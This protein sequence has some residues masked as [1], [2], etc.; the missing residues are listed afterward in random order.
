MATQDHSGYAQSIVATR[1]GLGLLMVTSNLKLLHMN[2]KAWTLSRQLMNGQ[3][4]QADGKT[5]PKI[6]ED[7]CTE[8]SKLLPTFSES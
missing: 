1:G 7:F 4:A 6:L 3:A 2:Q 8:I 5:L